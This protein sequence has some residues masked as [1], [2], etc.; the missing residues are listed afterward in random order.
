[1]LAAMFEEKKKMTYQEALAH[2]AMKLT[3]RLPQVEILNLIDAGFE[4]GRWPKQLKDK[5]KP[6]RA[7]HPPLQGA[8]L[9]EPMQ[10]GE[11]DDDIDPETGE[12]FQSKIARYTRMVG[13]AE[14]YN[15]LAAFLIHFRIA[16]PVCSGCGRAEPNPEDVHILSRCKRCK[17]TFYCDR[18]C[19]KKHYGEIHKE[20]CKNPYT[21]VAD[22]GY[23]AVKWHF[24]R[25]QEKWT[26]MYKYNPGRDY[27]RDWNEARHVQVRYAA[28]GGGKRGGGGGT[29][30]PSPPPPPPL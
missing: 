30:P 29:P 21:L 26:V 28:A 7:P 11:I 23:A 18:N 20:W 15:R 13:G 2:D 3:H 5:E 27:E 4:A 1:M 22:K 10:P 6:V 16:N 9:Q 19:Q 17:M 8:M 12:Y 24:H 14:Q 25:E